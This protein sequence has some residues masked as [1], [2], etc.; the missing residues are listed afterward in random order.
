MFGKK[1]YYFKSQLIDIGYS[2]FQLNETYFLRSQ[3]IGFAS[4][5]FHL[6]EIEFMIWKKISILYLIAVN[7]FQALV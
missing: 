6:I 2:T 5:K 4:I 3:L 7:Y 1:K